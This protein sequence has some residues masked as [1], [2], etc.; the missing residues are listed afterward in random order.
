MKKMGADMF[1]DFKSQCMS[2]D[3]FCWYK[4]NTQYNQVIMLYALKKHNEQTKPCTM[5]ID[6]K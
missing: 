3:C 2:T 6:L 5:S 1:K 4:R